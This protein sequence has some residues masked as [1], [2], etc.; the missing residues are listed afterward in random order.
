MHK[1]KAE[2]GAVSREHTSPS[3]RLT[4]ETDLKHPVVVCSRG[5]VCVCV[6]ESSAESPHY[7]Q[8]DSPDT[9]KGA[10]RCLFEPLL[11]F[12]IAR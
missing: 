5:E 2:K 7:S 10:S 3:Q 12:L 1:R 9:T 11:D 4:Y 6:C 8:A